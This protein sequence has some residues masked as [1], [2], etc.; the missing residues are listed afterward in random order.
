MRLVQYE[1]KGGYTDSVKPTVYIETT[2]PSYLAARPSRDLLVTAFQQMTREWWDGRRAEFDLFV[3]QIV[4]DEAAAGDADAARRRLELLSGVPVLEINE[5]CRKLAAQLIVGV[6]IPERAA[7]DA[8]H[9]AVAAVNKMDYLVT[10]NCTH[11][12]NATLRG[13]IESICAANGFTAPTICTP[14][15]LLGP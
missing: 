5:A 1:P 6:P 2:I 3:S 14:Q 4:L 11:I 9:V 13:R 8:L 12:A 15:E 10:W 7:L